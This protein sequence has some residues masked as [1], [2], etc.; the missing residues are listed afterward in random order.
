MEEK[1]SAI[2][3][4]PRKVVVKNSNL[5]TAQRADEDEGESL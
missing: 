2:S 3:V 5:V 4:V 1:E